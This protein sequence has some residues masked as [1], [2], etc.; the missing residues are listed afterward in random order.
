AERGKRGVKRRYGFYAAEIIFQRNMLVGRM[1][2]FV[3]QTETKKDAGHFESVVHLR[4]KRNRAAFA[5][6]YRFFAK[7]FFERVN[8]LLENGMR[9]GCDP[10]LTHA[11]HFKFAADGFGQQFADV[12]LDLFRGFRGILI[13]H[14]ASRDFCEGFGGNNGFRTFACL[15]SPDSVE[16]ESRAAPEALDIRKALFAGEAGSADS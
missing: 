2:V 5:D 1:R 6:E 12:A 16:L 3:G 7:A 8:C 14:Q 10:R 11:E 4:D 9:I 15:A 13:R